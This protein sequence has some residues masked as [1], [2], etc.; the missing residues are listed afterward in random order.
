M[1]K[2]AITIEYNERYNILAEL[3]GLL[4]DIS[5]CAVGGMLHVIVD[6]DNIYTSAI[7]IIY[8]DIISGKDDLYKGIEKYLAKAILEYLMELSIWERICLFAML[9]YMYD[10]QPWRDESVF[11]HYREDV[12]IEIRNWINTNID[13]LENEFETEELELQFVPKYEELQ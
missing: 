1:N 5:G 8:D 6:D 7:N 4:Y 10:E 2:I 13:V 3:I 12:M 11:N 9:E